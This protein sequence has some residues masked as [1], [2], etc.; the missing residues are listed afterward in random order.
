MAFIVL[1]MILIVLVGAF[2][3]APAIEKF[4]TNYIKLLSSRKKKGDRKDG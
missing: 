1:V 4:I 2:Y 3:I